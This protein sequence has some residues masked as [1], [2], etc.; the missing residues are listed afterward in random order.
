MNAESVQVVNVSLLVAALGRSAL[1]LVGA[2]GL[3]VS[4][5]THCQH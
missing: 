1:A 5:M 2:T 3:N 4:Y